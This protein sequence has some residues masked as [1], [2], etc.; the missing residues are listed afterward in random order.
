MAIDQ[1]KL[2][3][4]LHKQV[5]DIGAAMSGA[6]VAIGEKLGL[7]KDLADNGPATPE[8]LAKRTS[9]AERYIREWSA[10]QA[11]GGYITYDAS[12]GRYSLTEEQAFCLA[13]ENSPVYLAG[14]YDVVL[15]SQ[16]ALPRVLENFRTGAGMHWGEHDPMLFE[17]VANFFRPGYAANLVSSWIPALDGVEEKLQRGAKVADVGCGFGVSTILM[18]QAH[19]NSTFV[20]F[21]YHGPSMEI[22][23][24]RAKG[25]GVADRVTFEVA[26]STDYPGTGYDFV[27]FFDCFH[28]MEDPTGAARHVL[29]TLEDDGCWMLVEPFAKDSVEENLNP[30]GRLFYAASTMICVP[31]SLAGNG[32]GL[33][34]QAGEARLREIIVDRGGFTRFRRATETPFNLILEARP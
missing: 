26:K 11:A 22:A 6:L 1:E 33:G 13:D 34:A 24:E 25:A 23:T 21:D 15:A 10:S 9:T 16:K 19:P 2:E 30:V 20:G 7:Y 18:A 4:F 3:E 14:A 27:T 17:G 29:T 12:S 31:N 5:G 28:D 8:E 32:P